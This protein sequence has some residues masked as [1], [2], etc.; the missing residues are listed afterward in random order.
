MGGEARLFCDE[1]L[2][3]LGRWLRAAGHDTL[4]AENG[5]ADRDILQ[6]ARAEDRH[7]LTRDRKLLEHR[8]ADGT[9]LLLQGETL[10]EQ[11][12]ELRQRLTIDWL[13]YPF[14]RCLVCNTPVEA[15]TPDGIVIPDD[16]DRG[17]LRHCPGCARVY[18]E[19]SHTRRMRRRLAQWASDDGF[20]G[21]VDSR[22]N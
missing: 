18:W 15:G 4:I 14:S 21:A 11:A 16:V 1:M 2:M 12:R 5:Q 19:G 3:R 20:R 17:T 8:G 6:R 9:V 22:G 7:L 10:D 13:Y